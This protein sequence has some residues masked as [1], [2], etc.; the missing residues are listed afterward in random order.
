MIESIL[1]A[2]AIALHTG[3]Y[4]AQS[5]CPVGGSLLSTPRLHH[6]IECCLTCQQVRQEVPFF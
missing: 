6:R 5:G 1:V 3:V 2:A 4:C